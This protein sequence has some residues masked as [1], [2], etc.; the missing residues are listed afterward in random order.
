MPRTVITGIT[1]QGWLYLDELFVAKGYRV[2]GLVRGQGNQRI[3]TAEEFI[4]SIELLEGDLRGLPN[5]IGAPEIAHRDE[6]DNLGAIGFVGLSWKPAEPTGGG[7]LRILEAIRIHTQNGMGRVHSCQALGSQ[8]FSKVHA[9]PRR[10]TTAFDGCS[11]CVVCRTFGHC[12]LVDYR[13]LCGAFGLSAILFNHESPRRG[14]GFLNHKVTRAVARIPL[15]PRHIFAPGNFDTR[16]D[17]GFADD[18][19]VD[20]WVPLGVQDPRFSRFA[21]VGRHKGGARLEAA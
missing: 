6:I 12:S 13:E 18:F 8:K 3:A 21:E 10:E 17:R 15:G 4:P 9:T 2:Y 1:R 7:V 20:D 19:G 14:H 5:L 11:R 16:R